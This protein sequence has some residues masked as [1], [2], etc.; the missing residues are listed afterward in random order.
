MVYVPWKS[1]LL[2]W[3]LISLFEFNIFHSYRNQLIDLRCKLEVD[4][5]CSNN[6]VILSFLG[7]EGGRNLFQFF[8]GDFTIP[9]KRYFRGNRS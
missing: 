5:K 6:P 1:S 2:L 9:Q 8:S 7:G 3:I 4:L